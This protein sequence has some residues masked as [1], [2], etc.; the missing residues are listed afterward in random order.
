MNKTI[1]IG[2]YETTPKR[3]LFLALHLLIVIAFTVQILYSIVAFSVVAKSGTAGLRAAEIPIE[4][5]VRRRLY[6]IE[7]WVSASGLAVYLGVVY[8]KS[9]SGF[10]RRTEESAED[11]QA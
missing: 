6:A 7:L 2:K 4:E 3:L 11:E 5:M 10:F 9:L 8:H 1:R